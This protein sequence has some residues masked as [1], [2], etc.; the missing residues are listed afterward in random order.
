MSGNKVIA[1]TGLPA[2]GKTLFSELLSSKLNCYLISCDKIVGD[3]YKD[4]NLIER[5]FDKYSWWKLVLNPKNGLFDKN[6][7]KSLIVFNRNVLH[8]LQEIFFPLIKHFIQ[9]F[10]VFKKNSHIVVEVPLL[11]ESGM[12]KIFD[13]TIGLDSKI[14]IIMERIIKRDTNIEMYKI[15]L[16]LHFKN[17]NDLVDVV[18]DNNS[19]LNNLDRQINKKLLYLL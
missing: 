3:F 16:D 5:L 18:I 15:F 6:L 11:F 14:N 19:D 10:I 13:I 7:L 12:E 17:K 9:Q 4:V 2:S 8:D 1:V